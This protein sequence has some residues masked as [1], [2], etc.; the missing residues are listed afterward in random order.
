MT[1]LPPEV[2]GKASE[3]PAA[4]AELALTVLPPEMDHAS[5]FPAA[6]EELGLSAL[7]SP[8]SYVHF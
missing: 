4:A 3:V 6:A 1:V 2:M 8:P 7:T 5:E